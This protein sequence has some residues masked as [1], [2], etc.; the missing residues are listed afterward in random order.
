M[1]NTNS[2]WFKNANAS[3]TDIA[4][5]L[6]E[7][8]E[9]GVIPMDMR[10]AIHNHATNCIGSLPISIAAVA[11][12]LAAAVFGDAGLS[13]NDTKNVAYGMESLAEQLHGWHELGY[14]FEPKDT[15]VEVT[16]S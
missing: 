8:D 3:F 7:L 10:E 16:A 2:V 9:K 6:I 1:A 15:D 4:H 5:M 14:C 12:S 11:S 13:R